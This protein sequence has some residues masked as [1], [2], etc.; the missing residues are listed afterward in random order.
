[1]CIFICICVKQP[2]P[3]DIQWTH[4]SW[5]DAYNFISYILSPPAE[6]SRGSCLHCTVVAHPYASLSPSV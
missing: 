1:M 2:A 5:D 6:G 3:Q 4:E